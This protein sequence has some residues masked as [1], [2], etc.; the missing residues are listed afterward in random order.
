M[1]PIGRARMEK[2]KATIRDIAKKAGVSET[3]VSLC[4]RENSRI[5]EATRQRVLSVAKELRYIPSHAARN[6]RFG[7][8]NLL[9]IVVP[10]VTNPFHA[11]MIQLA[12]RIAA[13]N[14]YRILFAQSHWDPDV[15]LSA[16]RD[17]VSH[18]VRGLLVFFSE[19]TR[20][21]YDLILRSETPHIAVDTR[22]EFYEGAYV[23][24]DLENSGRLA[25]EH[26]LDVGCRRFAFLGG[27]SGPIEYSAAGS[28]RSGFFGSLL[29]NKVPQ[30]DLV[31]IPAGLSI[32]NGEHAFS[33]LLERDGR[34]D[35]VYCMNDLCAIGAMEAARKQGYRVGKDVKIM[36]IDN[37][38]VSALSSISLTSIEE[39]REE[40]VRVALHELI[41]SLESGRLPSVRASLA[42]ELVVR[43]STA[44]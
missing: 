1:C 34:A 15:E 3:T 39:P 2:R 35:G 29:A 9:G 42:A 25:A 22:P 14:E 8:N 28:L 38:E 44:G 37:L 33:T 19:K 16:V 21:S 17:L 23:I 4:F 40:I 31:A 10:D 27:D 26:L 13:K 12:D 43:S 30:D 5:S 24:N 6:L 41:S 36:G 7:T 11:R 20:E 18:G 32:A